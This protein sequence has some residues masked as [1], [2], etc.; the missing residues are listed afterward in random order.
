MNAPDA[1]STHRG[2]VHDGSCP[3]STLRLT[4]GG[5][6]RKAAEARARRGLRGPT[7]PK[8]VVPVILSDDQPTEET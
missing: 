7:A 3:H 1:P 5:Y 8:R 2:A 4:T 6:A